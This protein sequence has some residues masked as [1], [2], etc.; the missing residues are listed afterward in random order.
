[1][2]D[3][4]AALILEEI[5][6]GEFYLRIKFVAAKLHIDADGRVREEL[7][8]KDKTDPICTEQKKER[9][10][11]VITRNTKPGVLTGIDK[12]YYRGAYSHTAII[13]GLYPMREPDLANLAPMRDGDFNCVAQR[14]L[15]HFEGALRGQG[16]T[17]LRRQK[18]QE[19]EDRVHDIGATV[20]DESKLEK[21]IKRPII[22]WDIAGGDIYNSGK[23][24]RGNNRT[25]ELLCHNGHAWS[26]DL[27]FPRAR[28]V[29]LYD[30][31]V[32]EA[33]RE[34][35]QGGPTAVWV[36]ENQDRT[37]DQFVLRDG[38]TYRTQ[39]VHEKIQKTC[40]AFGNK[41]LADRVFSENHAAWIVTKDRNCWKPTPDKLLYDIQKACVEHGHG[42]LWNAMGYDIGDIVSIDMKA[43]NPASFLGMGEAKRYFERFGHPRQRMTRVSING[44]LPKDIGTGFAEVQEW[45]FQDCHPII[46]AWFGK[47]FAEKGWA[48]T[49]LLVFL[50]D[51]GILIN[52]K[53]RE[54]IV[55]F[56]KQTE[57]WLP[58]DRTQGCIIMGKF[59][60]GG[61][62]DC[63][64]VTRRLITD[65]GELD[66]LVRDTLRANS[67]VGKSECPLG[68]HLLRRGTASVYPFACKHAS[69]CP[70]KP[71]YDAPEI[72]PGRGCPSGNRQHIS[73]ETRI[74][75]T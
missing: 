60:Q 50:V 11:V 31:D 54:A 1:M 49:Q 14:V 36:L 9:E 17:D 44:P 23:Y 53:I 62:E 46:P 55:A 25:L 65:Q 7:V 42:G 56:E 24:R 47:H 63:K 5:P 34:T 37:I 68:H 21:I 58:E 6:E 20:A 72:Y 35:I 19:W 22:L 66:F 27:C 4:R 75:Q 38:R 51:S 70:Y 69:I 15:E 32:W 48:P 3:D 2:D 29:H 57:V 41:S 33:I 64:T 61:K 8:I 52:L 12:P 67:F 39:G 74:A 28:T 59:T 16:L 18:I 43:C 40:K 30:G 26:K 73:P 10:V 13:Y 71:Y 45:Q